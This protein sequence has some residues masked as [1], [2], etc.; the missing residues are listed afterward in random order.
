MIQKTNDFI[1]YEQIK[2]RNIEVYEIFRVFLIFFV[3]REKQLHERR[4][5]VLYNI[6]NTNTECTI[7]CLI[8][9]TFNVYLHIGITYFT[10]ESG[11]VK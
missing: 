1:F 5:T 9:R 10:N 2:P 11:L 7:N 3:G 6:I 4:N 8:A